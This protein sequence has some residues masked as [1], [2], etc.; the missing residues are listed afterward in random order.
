MK[1]FSIVNHKGGVGKTTTAANLGAVLAQKKTVLLIDL[2]PQAALSA[3]FK[4]FLP[5]GK[6]NTYTCLIGKDK[7]QDAITETK[8]KNLYLLPSSLD[9]AAAEPELLGEIGFE[10]KLK[11]LVEQANPEFDFLLIDCPPSLGILTINAIVAAQHLII[12][13]QC[14]FLAMKAL[15]QLENIIEKAKTVNPTL[16]QKILFT[17]FS[18]RTT[19]SKEVVEEVRKFFPT[20]KTII[21]R[22]IKF[23]YSNVQGLPLVKFAPR[24]EQAEQYRNLA[25]EIRR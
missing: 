17:L 21:T 12:P 5:D 3:C 7:I 10:R 22:T 14:E 13:L 2:D 24:S 16:T 25:K 19:H 9:L 1:I 20:Y 11:S 23:A 4:I 18:K 15:A 8:I 6:P